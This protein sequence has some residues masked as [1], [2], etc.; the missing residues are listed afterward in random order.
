MAIITI[1]GT[2][3]QG[4]NIQVINN[5]VKVDE[6]FVEYPESKKVNIQVVGNV[7][8]LSVDACEKV[9][10]K[11]DCSSVETLSGDVEVSGEVKGSVS[12]MS[13]DVDCGNVYGSVSTMSGDID[14]KR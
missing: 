4:K 8:S 6:Q 14:Y 5:R 2:T 12:T 13:G 7:D 3:F 1:N 11:G 10:I 9:S